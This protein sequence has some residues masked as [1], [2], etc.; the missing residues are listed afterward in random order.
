MQFRGLL[1]FALLGVAASGEASSPSENAIHARQLFENGVGL[2]QLG[3][4]QK[5]ANVLTQAIETGALGAS[6]EALAHFDRGVA[7]DTLGETRRAIADYSEALRFLPKLG[8]ALSNRANIYRRLGQLDEA[9][10]DYLT[11]LSCPNVA[12]QYPYY[13]LGLIAEQTGD[14]QAARAYFQKALAVKPGFPLAAQ[15]LVELDAGAQPA[16][17]VPVTSGSAQ[18]VV[19]ASSPKSN[20]HPSKTQEKANLGLRQTISDR[21]ERVQA[22]A[23]TN[24]QLGAF[25]AEHSAMEAWDKIVSS[26]GHL[27]DGM[28]PVVTVTDVQGHGRLWRLRVGISDA[29]AAR[30]ICAVLTAKGHACM[31]ARN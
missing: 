30:R 11:A 5:A 17:T 22:A 14:K 3:Q 16:A 23:S 10:R 9:K 29:Q 4:Y 24:V 27:L 1:V 12:S 28:R 20:P 2:E 7:Y 8:A 6:D 18:P 31:L 21:A 25:R 19:D 15:S 26:A 13:G